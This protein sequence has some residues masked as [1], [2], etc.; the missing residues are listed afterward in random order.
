VVREYRYAGPDGEGIPGLPPGTG[1][2]IGSEYC[3]H[4]LPG[5]GELEK[6]ILLARDR[7][8]PLL[9]LTPYFRDAEL[10][11]SMAL[12]RAIPEGADVLVAVND[13]GVLLALRALFP[14]LPLSVGRL[15]SGQKRCPRIAGSPFLTEKGRAWHGEGFFSSPRVRR[16]LREEF[17]VVGFH[18]DVL[19]WGS[20]VS[21]APADGEPA[22]SLYLHGPYSIV[23]VSDTCAWIG[24][25]SSS[26]VP[27]CSRPC[28]N[29]SVALR[30]GTMGREMIQQGKARFVETSPSSPSVPGDRP[31]AIFV[32]YGEVP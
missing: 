27:S 29:G 12:F 8:A 21:G 4:L 22:F 6:A 15:L 16:Y 30:E 17:G 25:V 24:G 19:E 32:L 13:W 28:R 10:K 31:S 26:S 20:P 1:A 9:L 2:A 23:T 11:K 7:R 18:A 5:V 3:V 14:R